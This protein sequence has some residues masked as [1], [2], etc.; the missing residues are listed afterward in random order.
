MGVSGMTGQI[1]HSDAL[2]EAGPG[3]ESIPELLSRNP[4]QYTKDDRRRAI[5]EFQLQRKNWMKA[6]QSGQTRAQSKSN[7]Q[8]VKST[9]TTAQEIF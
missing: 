1:P 4:E 9:T 2:A 3:N 8:G 5:A 6:E 7:Q